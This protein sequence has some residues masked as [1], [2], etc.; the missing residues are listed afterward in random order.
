MIKLSNGEK[1]ISIF[2]AEEGDR[3]AIYLNALD[4]G[5]EVYDSLDTSIRSSFNLIVVS[6][7][8][9]NRDMSPWSLGPVFKDGG[10]FS[11]GAIEYLKLLCTDLI[12]LAEKHING[13]S[14]FRGIAGYSLAGAFALYSL[15]HT[16]LFSAAASM[17]GSLWYP[18]LAEYIGSHQMPI[19]PNSIYISLGDRERRTGNPYMRSVQEDTESI[20]RSFR[21]MG[22]RTRYVLEPGNHFQ[23]AAKRTAAG[24]AWLLEAHNE[25]VWSRTI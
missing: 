24:I 16:E 5:R 19:Q 12:P 3:P 4:D 1:D 13:R 6:G 22:I 9:W 23:N 11:G 25:K 17:S 18:G 21:E 2:P 7:L 10:A 15:Y 14:S 20:V 8:E